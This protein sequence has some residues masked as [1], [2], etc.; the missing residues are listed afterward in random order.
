MKREKRHEI[1]K[2][3]NF[4]TQSLPRVHAAHD[5][6][7]FILQASDLEST[8]QF[9]PFES[10]PPPPGVDCEGKL[11][12]NEEQKR[13]RA[14][15]ETV[16]STAPQTLRKRSTTLT[17]GTKTSCDSTTAAVPEELSLTA[18]KNS[19]FRA[20]L[21]YLNPRPTFNPIVNFLQIDPAHVPNFRRD[22]L[23]TFLE[24]LKAENRPQVTHIDAIKFYTRERNETSPRPCFAGGLLYEAIHFEVNIPDTSPHTYSSSVGE[25]SAKESN[26]IVPGA[27]LFGPEIIHKNDT[28]A[29]PRDDKHTSYQHGKWTV[30]VF[31]ERASPGHPNDTTRNYRVQTPDADL[32][33]SFINSFATL[34][35]SH[36]RSRPLAKSEIPWHLIAFPSHCICKSWIGV[37]TRH[38]ERLR[39]TSTPPFIE[40]DTADSLGHLVPEPLRFHAL[41]G[42]QGAN[43][44][45]SASSAVANQHGERDLH[46][47]SSLCRADPT[48]RRALHGA[49]SR[50]SSAPSAYHHTAQPRTDP[51]QRHLS[52][53]SARSPLSGSSSSSASS[54]GEQAKQG[55]RERQTRN[56]RLRTGMRVPLM[57]GQGIRESYWE[58][59]MEACRRGDEV[60]VVWWEGGGEKRKVS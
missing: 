39:H 42:S 37:E 45:V 30:F 3:R 27:G 17:S 53:E 49:T 4:L 20:L 38:S 21:A 41:S 51:T 25:F 54:P 57:E 35:L 5:R 36:S 33:A 31:V 16:I 52:G 8:L 29:E 11:V 24:W 43:K 59:W 14:P 15:E 48:H 40:A 58:A 22:L 56:I 47:L 13:R 44:S 2:N 6:M 1:R 19:P 18:G 46:P 26:D 12:I 34:N 55:T 7:Q 60:G 10:P 9:T 28:M 50:L 32:G 23:T